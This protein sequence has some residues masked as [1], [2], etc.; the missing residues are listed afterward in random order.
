MDIKSLSNFGRLF[1]FA[2]VIQCIYHFAINT[3]EGLLETGKVL[4]TE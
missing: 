2:L 3:S 1:C 4:V